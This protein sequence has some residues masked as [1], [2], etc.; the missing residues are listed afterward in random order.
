MT[1]RYV[2]DIINFFYPRSFHDGKTLVEGYANIISMVDTKQFAW[3]ES[4]LA[5]Q[6]FISNEFGQDAVCNFYLTSPLAPASYGMIF[7]V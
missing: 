6:N 4:Q 5:L 1:V 2:A 3:V 7:Q